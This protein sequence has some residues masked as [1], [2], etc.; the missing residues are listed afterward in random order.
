MNGDLLLGGTASAFRGLREAATPKFCLCASPGGHVVR[1]KSTLQMTCYNPPQMSFVAAVITAACRIYNSFNKLQS[2]RPTMQGATPEVQEIGE[3]AARL[4]NAH[5]VSVD[6]HD[7]VIQSSYPKWSFVKQDDTIFA[8][9]FADWCSS[10]KIPPDIDV[11]FIDTS[12]L[13]ENTLEELR[14]WMPY[15]SAK[16]KIILHDTNMRKIYR[17]ADGS[18][19]LGWDNARGVIRALEETLGVRFNEVHDF[20]TVAKGWLIRHWAPLQWSHCLRKAAVLISNKK[21]RH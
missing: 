4:S 18:L 3:R 14:L 1:R 5:L 21:P 2:S 19:Y 17:R 15:L 12:H 11:L 10:Q 13:Y 9:Q 20:V 6:L 7:C 16:S 8:R